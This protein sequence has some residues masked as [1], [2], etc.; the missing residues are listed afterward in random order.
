MHRCRKCNGRITFDA[1]FFHWFHVGKLARDLCPMNP[2]EPICEHNCVDGEHE[3][4]GIKTWCP[5]HPQAREAVYGKQKKPR[6]KKEKTM[7]RP[8]GLDYL[9]EQRG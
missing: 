2:P 6:A 5:I 3:V 8:A 9:E 4:I 7:A 1:S